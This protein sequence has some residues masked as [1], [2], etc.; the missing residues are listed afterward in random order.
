MPDVAYDG[1]MAELLETERLLKQ[2]RFE[3]EEIAESPMPARIVGL[4]DEMMRLWPDALPQER[5]RMLRTL[6]R[7]MYLRHA[8]RWREPLPDRVVDIEWVF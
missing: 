3:S 1:A 2:R 8:E 7:R 5:N 6:V 4:V